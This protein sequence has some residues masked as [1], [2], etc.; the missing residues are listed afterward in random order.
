[1]TKHFKLLGFYFWM[2][3]LFTVGRWALSFAGADYSKTTQIFS[4]VIISM[5]I[6]VTPALTNAS[7]R[8][9][10]LNGSR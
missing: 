5:L 4:L 1:M 9:G 10:S 7:I 2:L 8:P 6:A 3:G